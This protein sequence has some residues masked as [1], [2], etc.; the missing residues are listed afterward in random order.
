MHQDLL[1]IS[2]SVLRCLGNRWVS[3]V[4]KGNGPQKPGFV[5]NGNDSSFSINLKEMKRNQR[6]RIKHKGGI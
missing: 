2:S 3:F 6:L 5:I 1:F 4:G